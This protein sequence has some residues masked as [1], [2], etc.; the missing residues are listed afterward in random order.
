MAIKKHK[1]VFLF[2]FK[3]VLEI[4]MKPYCEEKRK[5]KE[6]PLAEDREG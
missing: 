6:N 2:S 1:S 5:E 3:L 4:S